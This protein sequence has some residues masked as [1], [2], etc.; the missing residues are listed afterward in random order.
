[1][2]SMFKV[3]FN[4]PKY[5]KYNTDPGKAMFIPFCPLPYRC[6]GGGIIYSAFGYGW[7]MRDDVL[8][9]IAWLERFV[10]QYP[11][12][13]KKEQKETYI[14]IEA[15]WYFQPTTDEK[16][17]TIVHEFYNER[18]RIKRENEFDTREKTIKLTINSIYGQTARYVGE[19]GNVP[20]NAN[21]YYAAAIT[22]A[23]RRRLM[24]AAVLDPHAIVFDA[25]DGIVSTR[26]LSGLTRVRRAGEDVELGDWE[27]CE[28]DGG[29][30]IQAGVYH[31]GKV[32]IGKDGKRRIEAVTKLR[33]ATAKNYTDDERGA[34]AWLIENTLA[35]WR[36]PVSTQGSSMGVS[37]PYEK[38]IT[39]GAGLAS[40]ER[41]RTAGRWTP[42]RG[43]PNAAHRVINVSDPGGKRELLDYAPDVLSTPERL[44]NRCTGLVRTIPVENLDRE[45][46]RP[47]LP[48]WLDESDDEVDAREIAEI[49][50]WFA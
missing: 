26:E 6:K 39:L 20:A 25:T 32:K 23:T 19:A 8:A 15:A 7:Y 40:P 29:L 50:A 10:P 22:A 21:P 49:N 17:F 30:F 31:Y 9:M 41:F 46:S 27:L 47:R 35:R 42:K 16:P 43:H 48:Q 14:D 11:S 1:M 36:A 18:K 12:L 44:S 45:M 5:E 33:G 13:P 34:G 28:A 3:K 38:Y 37:E 4:F 2:L 24:E